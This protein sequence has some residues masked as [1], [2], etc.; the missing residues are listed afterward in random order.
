M[1]RFQT[2]AL[3]FSVI[4]CFPWVIAAFGDPAVLFDDKPPLPADT[5][6]PDLHAAEIPFGL[7]SDETPSSEFVF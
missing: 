6:S 7:R 4:V 3:C 5:L 2:V 1:T